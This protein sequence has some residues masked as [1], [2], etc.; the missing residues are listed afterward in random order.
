M[1]RGGFLS[2]EYIV[3]FAVLVI[4]LVFFSYVSQSYFSQI[5]INE[6]KDAVNTLVGGI[7]SVYYIGPG[8][9]QSVIVRIPSGVVNA[10]I[11]NNE[12]VYYFEGKQGVYDV[13]GKAIPYVN[14]TLP[15]LMGL[16]HVTVKSI[17]S[18]L[19][20]ISLN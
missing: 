2:N 19:V 17:N 5:K 16:Y 8:N 7:N 9:K 15:I 13:H 11:K 3:L 6:A 4:M 20:E 12:I 18:T 1:K 14:G 10:V